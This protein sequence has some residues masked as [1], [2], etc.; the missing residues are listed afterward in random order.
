ME[1]EDIMIILYALAAALGLGALWLG[2]SLRVVQQ[3]ERGVVL[4][5]GV[6]NPVSV[7]RGSRG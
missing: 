1:V 6:C 5:F 7:G 3:F 4:R 2:A